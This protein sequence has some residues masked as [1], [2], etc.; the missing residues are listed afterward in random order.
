MQQRGRFSD[1]SAVLGAVDSTVF[2][3]PRGPG[4]RGGSLALMICTVGSGGNTMPPNYVR[5]S[6]VRTEMQLSYT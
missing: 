3:L 1:R 2:S 5:S 6:T 4:V